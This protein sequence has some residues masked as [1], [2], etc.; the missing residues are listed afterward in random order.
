MSFSRRCWL[1]LFISWGRPLLIST[2]SGLAM[3]WVFYAL[4]AIEDEDRDL[5]SYFIARLSLILGTMKSEDD[6]LLDGYI[7]FL[8]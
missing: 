6:W 7:I 8:F 4:S 2:F 1:E 5:A 3:G